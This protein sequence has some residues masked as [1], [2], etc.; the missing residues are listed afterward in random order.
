MLTRMLIEFCDV[1]KQF[2]EVRR[3]NG[4]YICL[5]CSAKGETVNPQTCETKVEKPKSIVQSIGRSKPKRKLS[6]NRPV[7]RVKKCSSIKKPK[8][9]KEKI[10]VL[11]ERVEHP[12][13][14][15]LKNNKSSVFSTKELWERIELRGKLTTYRSFTNKLFYAKSRGEIYAKDLYI[16]GRRSCSVYSVNKELIDNFESD[17]TYVKIYELIAKGLKTVTEI[18]SELGFTIENIRLLINRRLLDKVCVWK[19]V[20]SNRY[21]YVL[22]DEK[23]IQLLKEQLPGVVEVR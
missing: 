18:Q 16:N 1:C 23:H 21:Y 10:K 2:E 12:L 7:I 3:Q 17:E 5:R 15:F 14:V 8:K 22:R 13:L 20:G 4:G 19:E 6:N 9:K 11:K